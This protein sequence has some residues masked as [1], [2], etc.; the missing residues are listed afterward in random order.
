MEGLQR[1]EFLDRIDDCTACGICGT[2]NRVP[3]PPMGNPEAEFM[4]IGSSPGVTENKTRIPYS[5]YAG[6]NL[7]ELLDIAGIHEDNIWWSNLV[8]GWPHPG[9][10]GRDKALGK[11]QIKTCTEKWLFPEILTVDPKYILTLGAKPLQL[12]FPSEKISGCHG[13]ILEWENGIKILPMYEPASV[14]YNPLLADEIE[15]DFQR[16]MGKIKEGSKK[17]KLDFEIIDTPIEVAKLDARILEWKGPI[18]F[19][20]ETTDLRT[21]IAEVVGMS[22]SFNER[23]YYLPGD[24]WQFVPSLYEHDQL[25]A[26]NAM[27]ELGILFNHDFEVSHLI[28]DGM[29]A[30]SILG[31][32]YKGLKPLIFKHYDH[33]M[34]EFEELIGKGVKEKSA[35]EVPLAELAPYA[36]EDA[37]WEGRLFPDLRERMSDSLG[38]TYELERRLIPVASRMQLRG[39]PLSLPEIERARDDLKVAHTRVVDKIRN[40]TDDDEFNPNSHQQVLA[41][42][43]GL[44]SNIKT[45]G[46]PILRTIIREHPIAQDIIEAR[47]LSKL[48]GTYIDSLEEMYPRAYGS[49]NPTGTGTG[50]FSY[51]GFHI[52]G[53]QKVWG[54]NLQTIPKPKMW[55]DANDAESNLVRRCFNTEGNGLLLEFDYSQ[56]ELRVAAHIANERNMIAAYKNGEDIHLRMQTDAKLSDVLPDA[57]YDAVR[58]VAKILNFGLLYEPNDRSAIGVVLR[59][60]AEAQVFLSRTEARDLVQAKR[61]ATPGLVDYYHRIEFQMQTQGYVETELGRQMQMKW[62]PGY[63]DRVAFANANNHRMA[64]NMPIQGTAADI[65][66]MALIE[67]DYFL[68]SNDITTTQMLLTVHDSIVFWQ[69]IP[70]PI[71]NREIK[72]IMEKVYTLR[73]PVLVDAKVGKNLADMK[74]LVID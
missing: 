45:T 2:Y 5:G 65:I 48:K 22:I 27:Y 51:S 33:K 42:L 31:E 8:K 67:I 72:K 37:Y 46:A 12:F 30:A 7:R 62:L 17:F 63:S 74:E 10:N 6:D 43:K 36:A 14:A 28:D 56:I 41:L 59:A 49:I 35:D 18:A 15:A 55:E 44:G 4:V 47:H 19:D 71:V 54:V 29:V 24:R 40:F 61:R 64:V 70:D 26:H 23:T 13:Q 1:M 57:D 53:R 50:R 21:H 69:Q 52:K 16:I 9:S 60:C 66:K 32:P 3:V 68:E 25:I 38:D 34:K 39:L 20:F 73:V 11:R 58:R